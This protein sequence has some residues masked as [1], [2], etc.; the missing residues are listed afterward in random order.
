LQQAEICMWNETKQQRL[1]EL[2]KRESENL[3]TKGEE[4]ELEN[5]FSEL[6]Q[7]EWQKLNPALEREHQKENQIQGKISQ[8]KMQNAVLEVIQKRQNDLAKR[9]LMQ[10]KNLQDELDALRNER[11]RVLH[12]LVA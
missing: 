1:N 5:L 9:A 4:Q 6:E 2:Q 8:I 3:L 10:L 11:E 12:D 7:E